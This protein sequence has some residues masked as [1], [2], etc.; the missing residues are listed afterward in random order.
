[1]SEYKYTHGVLQLSDGTVMDCM[2]N[3]VNIS[4]GHNNNKFWAAQVLAPVSGKSGGTYVVFTKWGRVGEVGSSKEFP[5]KD[6][7]S[8]IKAFEDKFKSKTGLKWE[9]RSSQPKTGKY[10][11]IR[12]GTLLEDDGDNDEADTSGATAASSSKGRRSSST[13][14]SSNHSIET[15]LDKRVFE[16]GQMIFSKRLF[17][18]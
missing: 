11:M 16:L 13:G 7:A 3:Q 9:E 4:A 6:Q 17:D 1:M 8:A 12:G 14:A 5:Q 18:V 2:L 15:K 10:T